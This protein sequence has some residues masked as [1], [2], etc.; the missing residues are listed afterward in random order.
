[1]NE[2]P[3]DPGMQQESSQTPL[4]AEPTAPPVVPT[5]PSA[6]SAEQPTY[7]PA[8]PAYPTVQAPYA[9]APPTY[10]TAQAPYPP[11]PPAYPT[12]QPSYAPAPP[13]Y[14][15]AQ[16]IHPAQPVVPPP[17]ATI[18]A[19]LWGTEPTA[20]PYVNP[21][22]APSHGSR[23]RTISSFVAV[24][25]LSATLAAGGTVVALESAGA[26]KT[27]NSISATL[28]SQPVGDTTPAKA[29]AAP[30]QAGAPAQN[31]T[32]AQPGAGAQTGTPAQN[33]APA[34]PP[35]ATSTDP[36]GIVVDVAA[37]VSPAVVTII[38]QQGAGSS[39]S[40]RWHR[41]VRRLEPLRGRQWRWERRRQ[42]RCTP[43]GI[44]SGVIF[45]A[46]GW[47]L[48]NHHVVE[49]GSTLT[50]KLTDGRRFPAT[51]YGT[52]TLTDLAIVKIDATGLPTATLGDSA[53]LSHRPAGHRHRRPARR[54]HRTVTTGVVSGVGRSHRRQRQ[55]PRRPHPDGRR[56]QPR[57]QRRPVDRRERRRHRHRHGDASSAQG[58]GF[59]IPINLAN[60][61][62][63][64]ALAGKALSRPWLGIRYQP[65]DAGVATRN[66]LSVDQGAWITAGDRQR[67]RAGTE[68]DPAEKAGLKENDVIT[69]VDGTSVNG[70]HPLIELL[71]QHA[72]ATRSP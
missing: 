44:G 30:A 14:P 1:M 46:N 52:D 33:S 9:P 57:Q 41:S 64:Q 56:D 69:A 36:N 58:I 54:V 55:Q 61:W 16:P 5:A 3:F 18:P 40:T 60:R 32:P 23:P 35:V 19:T 22:A 72:P 21:S 49:G 68:P 70:K 71:A 48:T 47:I 8:P 10:P 51:V 38:S 2:R 62:P 17:P 67:C 24:A 42:R 26:L 7:A 12:V 53:A 15:T 59:A 29:P 20:A 27:G 39:G 37:R 6:G 11:A 45:D 43:T 65:L 28:S 66:R 63:Q 4:A 13:T 25:V 34:A 31:G 50:V